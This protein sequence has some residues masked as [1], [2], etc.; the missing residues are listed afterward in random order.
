[1]SDSLGSDK[2]TVSCFEAISPKRLIHKYI[3]LAFRLIMLSQRSSRNNKTCF[4][5]QS[6]QLL[7]NSNVQINIFS[8]RIQKQM[9]ILAE[10]IAPGNWILELYSGSIKRVWFH[11]S[12]LI[13]RSPIRLHVLYLHVYTWSQTPAQQR[14]ILSKITSK[15]LWSVIKMFV[16]LRK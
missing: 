11:I 6:S 13:Y 16:Y 4:N 1:M 14:M 7:Q 10:E 9:H 3:S 2:W 12:L 5:F 15:P 8:H